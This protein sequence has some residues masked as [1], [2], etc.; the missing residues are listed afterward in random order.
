MTEIQEFDILR[1]DPEDKPIFLIIEAVHPDPEVASYM[2]EEGDCPTNFLGRRE[3]E[4]IIVDGDTDPHGLFAYMRRI[5]R[6]QFLSRAHNPVE[7][8]KR[9]VPEAFD[10]PALDA[11]PLTD[12]VDRVAKVIRQTVGDRIGEGDDVLLARAAI[13]AMREPTEEMIEATW[14]DRDYPGI[15]LDKWREAID[16]ALGRKD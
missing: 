3:I 12:M 13:A 7:E 2:V 10:A 8:W 16:A 5:P 4:C 1:L 9:V 11:T 14:H 15:T 6:P